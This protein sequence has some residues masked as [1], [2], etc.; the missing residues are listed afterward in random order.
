[1]K[2]SKKRCAGTFAALLP[3]LLLCAP[4][5]PGRAAA[6]SFSSDSA[7]TAGVQFLKIASGARGAG[8]GEAYSAFVDD[9]FALDWNPAGLINIEAQ[10]L[11]FMHAPYLAETYL[12]Y[13]AYAEKAGE[14]GAWG[15]SG[16]YMNFGEL[17]H[18]DSSGLDMGAFTPYDM[19]MSV[20]LA[21]Y[22]TGFNKDPDERF[23]LGA[24]GK[25]VRS[26]II[27]ADS[28]LS[29]DI[30]LLTP[31][32]L[33]KTFR[34]ALTAQNIM[35][36][37]RFDKEETQLPLVLRLGSLISL[38]KYLNITADIVAARD[39]LPYLAAGSEARIRAYEDMDLF[40][41]AGFNTRAVNDT[42]GARNVSFGA[43]LRFS[44]YRLD[45]AF[46]P[47]GVLGSAHRISIS[48]IF[49]S[50]QYRR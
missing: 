44:G 46:S 33:D 23:V 38:S 32:M 42:S 19:S 18:T 36:T 28:T 12:D 27:S 39:Y 10:S 6:S 2:G 11:V 29:A 45:Y 4:L 49:S 21:C 41:R 20:G 1:M 22:I 24:T 35:G 26:K 16:K 15:V 17:R 8:L 34:M 13:F 5:C 40:L 48:M 3:W 50:P 37:L 47:F 43:G 31:L 30:G 25:F 7:G 9:A 14:V